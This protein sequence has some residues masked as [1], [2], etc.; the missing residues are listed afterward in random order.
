M[1]SRTL[2]HYLLVF[3]LAPEKEREERESFLGL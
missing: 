3:F 2:N 1:S